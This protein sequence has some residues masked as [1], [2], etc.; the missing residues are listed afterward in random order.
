MK[1]KNF[2]WTWNDNGSLSVWYVG[3]ATVKHPVTGETISFNQIHANH[4]SYYHS[5][6]AV[7]Y[8]RFADLFALRCS[9]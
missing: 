1:E 6:P 7:S 2:N 8:H 5:H 4:C 3:E 9:N